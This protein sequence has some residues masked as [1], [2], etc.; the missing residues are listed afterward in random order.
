MLKN[1]GEGRFEDVSA[2]VGL[3]PKGYGQ[4][5]TV[6]DYD[7]DGDPDVYVTRYGRNTL[8]RNDRDP[9]RFTDV[10]DGGRSC[11]RQ[12]EPRRGVR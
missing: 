7:G 11:L 6:A 1:L 9:G 10:T 3:A 4:G 5:A 12:L 2:R 8:W